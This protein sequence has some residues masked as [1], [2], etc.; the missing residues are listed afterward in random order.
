MRKVVLQSFQHGE[1]RDQ[2]QAVPKHAAHLH[3]GAFDRLTG[4]RGYAHL[5]IL[6]RAALRL[7]FRT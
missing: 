5:Q 7:I 2:S 1:G 3:P 4:S 6:R